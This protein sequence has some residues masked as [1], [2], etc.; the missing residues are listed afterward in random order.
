[1][2]HMFPKNRLRYVIAGIIIILFWSLVGAVAY[3]RFS[4]APVTTAYCND[5][6]C[7][8]FRDGSNWAIRNCQGSTTAEGSTYTCSQKGITG[9]CGTTSYCCPGPGMLWTADMTQCSQT[10]MDSGCCSCPSPTP[11]TIT[12]QCNGPCMGNANCTSGNICI[13]EQGYGWVCRNPACY[14]NSGCTCTLITPTPSLINTFTPVQGEYS[15][16]EF[17][18]STSECQTDLRCIS[19]NNTRQCRNPDCPEKDTCL[20]IQ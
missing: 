7:T 12:S 10:Q 5:Y 2:K 19:A 18:L 14:A 9:S 13:F 16:S 4:T 15:C 17:C 6:G 20:C 11:Y 1:M 8:N 3:K